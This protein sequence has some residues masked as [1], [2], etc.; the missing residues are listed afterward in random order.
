MIARLKV[1]R[2]E[3]ARIEVGG[4]D[5]DEIK[6]STS[7]MGI[8]FSSGEQILSG[9]VGASPPEMEEDHVR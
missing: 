2:R 3:P 6:D 4:V 9:Q 7:D 1:R 8:E 5:A